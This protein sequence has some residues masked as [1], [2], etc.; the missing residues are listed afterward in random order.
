MHFETQIFNGHTFKDYQHVED[1][2]IAGF[3][4]FTQSDVSCCIYNIE[5]TNP[6]VTTDFIYDLENLSS[7][8]VSF[9]YR[10]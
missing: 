10:K 8:Y 5:N 3:N 7:E 1:N 4:F 6:P 9:I 2:T